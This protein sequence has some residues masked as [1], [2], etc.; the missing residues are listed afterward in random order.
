[1]SFRSVRLAAS[2]VCALPV[3]VSCSSSSGSKPD[4][5]SGGSGGAGATGTGGQ[6]GGSAGG[7]GAAGNPLDAATDGTEKACPIDG[8]VVADPFAGVWRGDQQG[9][10]FTLT[11]SGG[12]STWIAVSA[13]TACGFC[14]GTY[15]V[16]G[17]TTATSAVSCSAGCGGGA[18]TDTG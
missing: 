3:L 8:A 10:T 4:A 2:L 11:N 18:H 9:I 1:M 14:G 7:S 13:G 17:P 5:A 6:G 16:T 12:C 15:T